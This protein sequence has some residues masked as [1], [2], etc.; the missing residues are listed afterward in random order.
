MSSFRRDMLFLFALALAFGAIVAALIEQPGYTDAYY[1]FNAAERF[2]DGDGL[3][4]PYLWTYIGAPD[5]LPEASHSYW[6]PLA[7]LLS[8]LVMA[9]G[10]TSF[11]VAQIP[12]VACYAGLVVIAY[13]VAHHITENRRLA[14][15]SGLLMLFSGFYVPYWTTTDS[16]AVFG[17][18]GSLALISIARGAQRGSMWTL[19]LAGGLVA[20]AHLTRADGLLFVIVLVLM[21]VWC[22]D[23]FSY[24]RKLRLILA[25]L[26][27]YVLVMAPWFVRNLDAFGVPLGVGG[28]QTAWLRG[29]NELVNYPGSIS[30]SDFLGWG[31]ENIVNSRLQ[32]LTNNLGTFVAVETWV[33]LGPFVFIGMWLQRK[34]TLVRTVF[35]Y[36]LGLHLAMT[37]VFAYPGYRGGLFHS[38]TALL[39]FWAASA[40]LGLDHAVEWA[41]RR[42]RWKREQ[43][44]RVFGTAAVVLAALIS[45]S[46]MMQRIPSLNANGNFYRELAS[47]VS[48]HSVLMVNDP[49]ALYYHTG[50]AGVVVPNAPADAV[51]EIAISYGVSH[52]LLDVNRTAPLDDLFLGRDVPSFLREIKVWGGQTESLSDDRRLFEVIA[53]ELPRQ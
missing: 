14:W 17:F 47:E 24:R 8:A 20:L 31:V 42:R 28:L 52:V 5:S 22:P 43:A 35:L 15:Q 49:P 21:V 46:A 2:A 51:A 34:T 11:A 1:Y 33:V 27:G 41:S 3:T 40:V 50:L 9:V 32:A 12:F 53:E 44:K 48:P 13:L 39:P 6:M 37:F 23:Q 30:L 10:G 38:A 16:F 36:A 4:D 29:Y 25:G 19:A 7:S 26:G 18:L 45:V